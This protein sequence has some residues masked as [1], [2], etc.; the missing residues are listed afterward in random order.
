[1]AEVVRAVGGFEL[2]GLGKYGRL[3]VYRVGKLRFRGRGE[4][5]SAVESGSFNLFKGLGGHGPGNILAPRR[6]ASS[7]YRER[8]ERPYEEAPEGHNGGASLGR[9]SVKGG[10]CISVSLG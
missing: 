1:V 10:V 3:L 7:P 2:P 5:L 8:G 4:E 6:E 9:E